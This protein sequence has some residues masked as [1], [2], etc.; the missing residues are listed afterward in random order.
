MIETSKIRRIIACIRTIGFYIH[1]RQY[2]IRPIISQIKQEINNRLHNKKHVIIVQTQNTARTDWN[3]PYNDWLTSSVADQDPDLI[4]TLLT[5]NSL[6]CIILVFHVDHSTASTET[7]TAWLA[8]L[9]TGELVSL[10][11]HLFGGHVSQ[12]HGVVL[13]LLGVPGKDLYL[14]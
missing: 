13:F 4:D 1:H 11:D 6:V 7:Q 8:A 2:I 14:L 10:L 5:D 3:F 9:P 12:G